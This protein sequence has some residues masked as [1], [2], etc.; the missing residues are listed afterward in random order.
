VLIERDRGVAAMIIEMLRAGWRGPLALTHVERVDDARHQLQSG[1][2]AAILLDDPGSE[3]LTG[4]EVIRMS[5]PDAPIIVLGSSYTDE[6]ALA[7]L[8][9]GA[10]DFVSKAELTAAALS[11][12]V[13]HAIERK[14]SEVQLTQR[15]LQDPLTGLPNRTLFIDRLGLALDRARRTGGVTG[16][17]F[18]DVDRFKQINDSLGHAA[19]DRVLI[20]LAERLRTVLRPMDTVARFG[21][22][23]FTFLFEDLSGPEEALAIADR[24]QQAASGPIV[25]G[26]APQTLDVSIGVATAS[27]P[28]MTP[29]GLIRAADKAMY[30]AKGAGGGGRELS[31]TSEDPPAADPPPMPAASDE[32]LLREALARQQL[33]VHYQPRFALGGARHVAGFE[34][35]VRWQHPTRG[36]LAPA[37]FLGLAEDTGMVIAI[38]EFVLREALR[39][40]AEQLN[41][42]PGLTVSVN[43]SARQLSD[44]GLPTALGEAVSR[45]GIDP[46]ALCI[47]IAEDAM[48]RDPDQVI[49]S[50]RA[51]KAVGV[52]IAID[53]Y[54]AGSAT[55][56]N[57]GQ[58]PADSLKIDRSL[59]AELGSAQDDG[60]MVSAVV[61]LAH[62]LGMS[63]VAEGVETN[64]QL[65]EL[66][67]LGCDSAQ[68]FLLCRP[69]GEDQL[70]ELL[71]RAA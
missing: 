47:E 13:L 58:I 46:G 61:E 62:A 65:S 60:T 68:G 12:A 9:G 23:E 17:L 52:L 48:S 35:L 15:A 8:R 14:Q 67:S 37:E 63:V 2:V 31:G 34:A 3:P 4:V 24:V 33:R 41:A 50:A 49:S 42:H 21:G 16:V 53:D 70:R 40:L 69:V 44:P 18:L 7:A 1:V 28:Q 6:T 20:S 59:I 71:T 45:A 27:D 25:L 38:G 57:L 26:G 55:L 43:I 29:D 54:S 11:R 56:R 19:G 32:E 66:R 10:Q 22:D 64:E 30:Q 51:I 36:L 39:Q 5:A